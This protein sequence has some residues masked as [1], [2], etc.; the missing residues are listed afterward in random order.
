V[1]S[2]QTFQPQI[3]D[4]PAFHVSAIRVA[5]EVGLNEFSP[6]YEAENLEELAVNVKRSETGEVFLTYQVGES[7][8]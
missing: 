8:P 4:R 5:F 2:I 1:Q 7:S 3:G 6:Q